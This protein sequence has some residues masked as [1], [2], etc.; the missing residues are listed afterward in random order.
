MIETLDEQY[1]AMIEAAECNSE[2]EI[3]KYT[4]DSVEIELPFS[5]VDP[6]VDKLAIAF[7]NCMPLYDVYQ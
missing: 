5:F 7:R 4:D 6:T 2:V 3:L 1:V